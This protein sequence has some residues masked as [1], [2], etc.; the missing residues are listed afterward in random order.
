MMVEL[1]LAAL[2]LFVWLNVETGIVSAIAY[3]V[4]LIGSVSTL[5]FNVISTA[6]Q[7]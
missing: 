6:A 3:N 4:M 2:A 7:P 5:F 1:F